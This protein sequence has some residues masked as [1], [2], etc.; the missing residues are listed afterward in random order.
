M[1]DEK[2]FSIINIGQPLTKLIECVSHHI[3]LG[4]EP[5]LIKARSEAEA[6]AMIAIAVAEE[7]VKL[8][9]V[10]GEAKRSP[11]AIR[12]EE[13]W[14]KLEMKRQINMENIVAKA[15]EQ[16]PNEVSKDPV[17]NDWVGRFFDNCKDVSDEEM[18][19][20]W[21]KLLAGEVAQP[22]SFSLRTLE[23]VKSMREEEAKSFTKL[24]SFVWTLNATTPFVFLPPG[25]WNRDD[26]IETIKDDELIELDSI[27]LLRYQPRSGIS[28]EAGS[29]QVVFT[30]FEEVN[31]VGT[32]DGKY[33]LFDVG[34]CVLTKSGM[35]LVSL[36]GSVRNDKYFH[37]TKGFLG[38]N[39][40]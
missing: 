8:I 31:F 29:S 17:H 19:V 36:A 15:A 28:W 27:G 33:E 13:R 30:Y 12:T 4:R 6:E 39:D 7:K 1:P 24:G 18:Q 10:E 25:V 21:S 16:L 2:H 22:G 38:F 9:R 32:N 11:L 40:D 26:L 35:E 20:L 23:I 34:P 37:L 3:A 5:G 14:L